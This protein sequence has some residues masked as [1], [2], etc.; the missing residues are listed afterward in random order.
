MKRLSILQQASW[1]RS[2]F[3]HFQ[4][5]ILH[6][7]VSPSAHSA[8]GGT[9]RS[10]VSAQD[11]SFAVK[12]KRSSCF[13]MKLQ[14]LPWD[15]H[16]SPEMRRT[17]LGTGLHAREGRVGSIHQE[18]NSRI[19]R[20]QAGQHLHSVALCLR[21]LP[22]GQLSINCRVHTLS[23]QKSGVHSKHTVRAARPDRSRIRSMTRGSKKIARR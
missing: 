16:C 5:Q 18:S 2:D 14:I 21:M 7:Q 3:I 4:T 12:S 15:D 13:F 22:S 8:D 19:W 1:Y 6:L 9:P 11:P 23:L 10:L 17:A 20:T